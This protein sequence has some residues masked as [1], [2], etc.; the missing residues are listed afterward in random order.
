MISSIGNLSQ[1]SFLLGKEV[2]PWGHALFKATP[3]LFLIHVFST[4]T[5]IAPT[6]NFNILNWEFV[7]VGHF[8]TGNYAPISKNDDMFLA[9]NFH[10]FGVTVGLEDENEQ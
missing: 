10:N 8:F 7:I 9:P 1:G 6:G 2:G 4:T 5:G 3:V